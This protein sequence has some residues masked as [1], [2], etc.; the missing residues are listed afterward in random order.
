MDWCGYRTCRSNDVRLFSFHRKCH[1][2]KCHLNIFLCLLGV[3]PRLLYSSHILSNVLDGLTIHFGVNFVAPCV[4]MGK[5]I[6]FNSGLYSSN[7]QFWFLLVIACFG[8]KLVS[9]STKEKSV[10]LYKFKSSRPSVTRTVAAIVTVI[11]AMMLVCVSSMFPTVSALCSKLMH[12]S[13]VFS[14]RSLVRR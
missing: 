1:K 2:E 11:E 7:W 8:G 4:G 13:P 5:T 3:S 14:A 10:I 6:W 9:F 12:N